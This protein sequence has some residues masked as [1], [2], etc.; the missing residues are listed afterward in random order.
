MAR[1]YVVID[2]DEDELGHYRNKL[3]VKTDATSSVSMVVIQI[4]PSTANKEKADSTV[5]KVRQW[6]KENEFGTVT[7]LNLFCLRSPK[8]KALFGLSCEELVGSRETK[9][10]KMHLRLR[11]RSCLRGAI[12]LGNFATNTKSD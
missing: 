12:F 6:A 11:T 5:G 8:R 10:L 1:K 7:F 9:W 4:N 3:V 2:C